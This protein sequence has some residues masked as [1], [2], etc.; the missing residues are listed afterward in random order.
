MPQSG[1]TSLSTQA[2]RTLSQLRHQAPVVERAPSQLRS[3]APASEPVCQDTTDLLRRLDGIQLDEEAILV[4]C[5]VECLYTSIR[6]CDGLEATRAFLEMTD[7]DAELGQFL[8]LK[9]ICSSPAFFEEQAADLKNRF[10][11]R[12]HSRKDIQR[13]YQRAKETLR[14]NLLAHTTK[15]IADD[16]IDPVLS[17]YLPKKTAI[18]YRRSKNL[19]D[20]LVHSHHKERKG[21]KKT[22][23]GTRPRH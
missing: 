9:R 5:D 11:E 16:Q 22:H 13:G 7:L 10:K 20:I 17:K 18:T 15:K 21:T 14:T 19:R 3:P 8:R 6:H 23:P 2:Q 4:T 1:R 12:G